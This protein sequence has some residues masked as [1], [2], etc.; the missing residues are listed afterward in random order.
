MGFVA[1]CLAIAVLYWALIGVPT[2]YFLI[3][4]CSR[5]GQPPGQVA[6]QAPTGSFCPPRDEAIVTEKHGSQVNGR[7]LFGSQTGRGSKFAQQLQELSK[8][9]GVPLGLDDLGTYEVEQLLKE[10][11]VIIIVSTYEKASPPEAAAWFCRWLDEAATDFRV[12]SQALSGTK[13][14]VFGCGNRQY[15]ENFNTVARRVNKQLSMLGGRQI[16]ECELGDEDSGYMDGQFEHWANKLIGLLAKDGQIS[17]A[18]AD[19]A[20]LQ[21]VN[22]ADSGEEGS[23][24]ASSDDDG[25]Q[26]EA[27]EMD[28]EDLAGKAPKRGDSV[29][30][31]NANGRQN[32]KRDMLTPALRSSLSKQGYKLIGSH[33]GVKLCRWTKSMLRGRGGCYKHSFYGIESHRC[34]EMTPSLACANKCVFCWRHHTNPVGREWKWNMDSAQDIVEAALDYHVKMI[35]EYKGVPGVKAS[36]LEQGY[37]VRHCALSLVGEPIMYPEINALVGELHGRGVSTFLVT[38]A[39]FPDQIRHLQPVTQLYVSVDAAS[40]E[41]LKA[42]DRPLFA[43]FWERFQEC[44]KLLKDKKQRTVYRLTLVQGWNMEDIDGYSR[45]IQLGCPDF[46]EIKG[47]TYCGNSGASGLTMQN[48]PYHKDVCD[49]AQALCDASDGVYGVACEHE[50]SCCVLCARRDRFFKSGEWHTWIDYER[51][52]ALLTDGCPFSSEDYLLPTPHWAVYGAP[53]AGFDPIES[54]FKKERRHKRDGA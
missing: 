47:V 11:L 6:K 45:L 22:V 43:D 8:E 39:Q 21:G 18:T 34:M 29:G 51:F 36:R 4:L 7:I 1:A 16:L 40:K 9:R 50:H 17:C 27:N 32:G 30:K 2:A 12:G 46:I 5:A 10:P 35:N 26:N 38:N 52:Q 19:V 23:Y 28:I 15:E 48:V 3:W 20:V 25:T 14:A 42:V 37:K 53:E 31:S 33:S 44:M 13:F 24:E 41:S 54:R 49:F